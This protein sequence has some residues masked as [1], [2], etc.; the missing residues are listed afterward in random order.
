[1]LLGR[2]T[3]GIVTRFGGKPGGCSH[4]RACCRLPA[5]LGGGVFNVQRS[6]P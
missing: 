2:N 4:S 3:A 1:M 5:Y 6:P